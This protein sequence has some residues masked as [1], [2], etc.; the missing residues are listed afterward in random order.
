M[1]SG[2]SRVGGFLTAVPPRSSA[3]AQEAL[4]LPR[5]N[6]ATFI[7]E[8]LVPAGTRLQRS[9]A[10]LIRQADDTFP[11]R[12]GGAEQ[13]QLLDRIPHRE[14][15]TRGASAMIEIKGNKVDFDGLV[16][17]CEYPVQDARQVGG[18]LLVLYRP[19]SFRGG[20]FRNLVAFNL[21]GC[22]VWRA[23]LPTSM[24]MD[25]YYQIISENPIVANSYCSYR[26]TLEAS[27]GRII[28]K[29]LFK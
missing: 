17:D 4:A 19:E 27:T 16:L 14:F 2:E 25:A 9:R 12:C 20:Q 7:Q 13:F 26:C 23:E 11:I 10:L 28:K 29:E 8:V 24:G 1:F 6:S 15:R 18:I 22:E 5:A 21:S 3:F